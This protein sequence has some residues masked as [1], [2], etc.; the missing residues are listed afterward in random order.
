MNLLSTVCYMLL[1]YTIDEENDSIVRAAKIDDEYADIT[2]VIDHKF[3]PN[4]SKR[5]TNLQFLLTG[6]DD[7][8]LRTKMVSVERH[9]KN[10]RLNE[11]PTEEAQPEDSMIFS[12]PVNEPPSPTYTPVVLSIRGGRR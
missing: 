3:V 10:A 7:S 1:C 9:N 4:N 2:S 6:E 5:K 12:A 11:K 8:E